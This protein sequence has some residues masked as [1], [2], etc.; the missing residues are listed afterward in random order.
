MFVRYTDGRG[1]V[2][3][4][5]RDDAQGRQAMDKAAFAALAE[6]KVES[7]QVARTDRQTYTGGSP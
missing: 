4:Y 2:T 5:E 1:H 3:G 7:V 6:T